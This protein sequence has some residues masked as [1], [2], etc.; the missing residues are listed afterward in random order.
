[1][2]VK[3]LTVCVSRTKVFFS[4]NG[5]KSVLCGRGRES[6]LFFGTDSI[7]YVCTS[8]ALLLKVPFPDYFVV[9]VFT[10]RLNFQ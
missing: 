1:M 7:G 4:G 10:S 3:L 2:T 9:L 5:L 6:C 8:R